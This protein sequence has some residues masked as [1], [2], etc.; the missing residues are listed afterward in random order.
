MLPY[1]S[2]APVVQ[3]DV[4]ALVPALLDDE[5]VMICLATKIAYYHA[6]D[7][8]SDC[9]LECLV[10]E[11]LSCRNHD[12][13]HRDRVDMNVMQSYHIALWQI[14]QYG[15]HYVPQWKETSLSTT[16]RSRKVSAPG[17]ERSAG[18]TNAPRSRRTG[19]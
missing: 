3:R 11:I 7:Y 6:Q 2:L 16:K 5:E 17:A 12:G 4:L 15:K 18:S 14:Q 13:A 8:V 1:L 10:M 9:E 19:T